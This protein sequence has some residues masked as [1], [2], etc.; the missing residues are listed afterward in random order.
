M[1]SSNSRAVSSPS[2]LYFW[3]LPSPSSSV[4]PLSGVLISENS[5]FKCM[6]SVSCA[7]SACVVAGVPLS[8][9]F[10]FAAAGKQAEKQTDG[11]RKTQQAVA[12]FH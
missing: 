10:F 7:V 9:A 1:P 11:K 3:E 8:S 12:S 5:M 4:T 6:V 2:A